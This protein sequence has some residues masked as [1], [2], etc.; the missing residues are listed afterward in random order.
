[1][2]MASVWPLGAFESYPPMLKPAATFRTMLCL[3]S[4]CEITHHGQPP[5]WFRGVKRIEYPCC[6]DCQLFSNRLYSTRTRRAF[7]SSNRFLTVHRVAVVGNAPGFPAAPLSVKV[8]P[9]TTQDC[10]V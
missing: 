8:V 4:A 5:S 2:L 9:L 6:A 10:S 7:F 1:M 3:K